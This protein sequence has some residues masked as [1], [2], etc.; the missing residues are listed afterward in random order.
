M[1]EGAGGWGGRIICLLV[2]IIWLGF[3]LRLHD[4]AVVPLR[5][6]EAFSALN[7]TQLP[8][9]RS[10]T[11][12]ASFD[13]HP[14]LTYLIFHL[15]GII[16]GGIGS[17]FA[18]RFLAV[19][20]NVVGIAAIFA[21]GWRL[22]RKRTV[23]L[24]AALMWALHPFEIWHS[25]DFRNYAVWAGFSVT[26]LWLGLRLLDAPNRKN[27]LLYALAAALSAFTFYTELFIMLALTLAAAASGRLPRAFRLR[28]LALL[29]CITAAVLFAFVMLVSQA[30]DFSYSGNLQPFAAADYL[31]RLI[32]ALTLA[33]AVPPELPAAWLFL[34]T[35]AA[36]FAAAIAAQSRPQFIFITALAAVP[37]LMIGLASQRISIFHPRY[38]LAAVPAFIL[39]FSLGSFY[40]AGRLHKII[41]LSQNLWM[42]CLLMPWFALALMTL[43]NHFNNPD[44]RKSP[45]W[46]ELGAFLNDRVNERDLVVQLSA[47][48]AFGYYYHGAARDVAL[49]ASPFQPAAE[50]TAAL[51]AASREYDSIYVVSNAIATWQ[52]A[53]VAVDWMNANM[54]PVLLSDASGLGI[55]QYKNWEVAADFEAALA[56]F[57]EV[58]ELVDYR[59]FPSPLPTGELLLWLYWRPLSRAGQP[60]KS[61]VH[62][63]GDVDTGAISS[64]DDQFPW[65]DSTSWLPGEVFRE[66]YVLPADML[67]PGR[68]HLLVG[69]YDPASGSRLLTVGGA[70]VFALTSFTWH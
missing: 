29:A 52:N 26:A 41:P 5:G 50:I 24:L 8:L 22:S 46:D 70:E 14:P 16:V 12:I 2:P 11:Q 10:L 62:I 34:C 66:V 7:W 69:W 59:F 53:D 18:L 40:L 58:V 44:W 67:L 27:W 17:P 43:H 36:V 3:F 4:L 48:A 47:D 64:Q 32:P 23:G 65:L 31:T 63:V 28:W 57:A 51:K 35:A 39:L 37:L 60:L 19:L 9:S 56:Q 13:P 6:D 49:P 38:V 25:Q 30:A 55:R 68:Y 61:F 1:G 15:W 33:E 21:L 42:L 20:G 45:A 54:Q